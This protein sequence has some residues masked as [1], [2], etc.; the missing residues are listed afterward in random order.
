MSKP[1]SAASSSLTSLTSTQPSRHPSISLQ[2]AQALPNH[3]RSKSQSQSQLHSQASSSTNSRNTTPGGLGAQ[4]RSR[5]HP[6]ASTAILGGTERFLA[7][8][9]EER[10]KLEAQHKQQLIDLEGRFQKFRA[11]AV[12]EQLL[13]RARVRNLEAKAELGKEK[14]KEGPEGV[15]MDVGAT[16]GPATLDTAS[17]LSS[18]TPAEHIDDATT[19]ILLQ[20]AVHLKKSNASTGDP[21]SNPNSDLPPPD[22]GSISDAFMPALAQYLACHNKALQ[23]AESKTRALEAERDAL[24]ADLKTRVVCA[25]CG[26]VKERVDGE[27]TAGV[28]LPGEAEEKEDPS[29]VLDLQKE[30]ETETTQEGVGATTEPA[31]TCIAP[32]MLSLKRVVEDVT[33]SLPVTGIAKRPRLG[34][35]DDYNIA[36]PVVNGS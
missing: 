35:M 25:H 31:V 16:S 9:D 14:E 28:R 1:A 23:E 24:V 11:M 12:E 30:T 27:K 3:Q 18:S 4:Q 19:S 6:R 36:T 29:P 26:A 20:F 33:G 22:L 17:T 2:H 32:D 8:F 7:L 13:L 10:L 34:S 5:P 15:E 21:A